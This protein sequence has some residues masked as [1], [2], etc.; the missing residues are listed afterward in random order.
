[1]KKIFSIVSA[2]ICGLV[3]SFIITMCFVKK[4]VGIQNN[5]PKFVTVFNKST[6]ATASNGY[7]EGTAEY[8]E[9][10]NQLKGLTNISLFNRLRNGTTLK[11]R[12][13]QDMVGKYTK[14][15]TALKSN[16]IVIELTYDRE[17]DVVVYNGENTR[18]ISY[19]CLAYVIP[20]SNEFEDVLV[21]YSDTNDSTKK[22]T[23]YAAC[24]PL[25][26]KGMAKK[27]IKYVNSL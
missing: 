17:Q 12:I 3:F 6:T 13:D 11:H 20:V 15:S 19:F 24:N 14:W 9:T 27:L 8:T 16:N 1:M 18:V 4:N 26:V 2:V 7:E 5:R 22:D 23:R 25:I 21:Y 10:L